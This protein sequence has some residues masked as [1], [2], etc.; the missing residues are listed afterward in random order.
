MTDRRP[1]GDGRAATGVRRRS[2]KR[3]TPRGCVELRA[4]LYIPHTAHSG[5]NSGTHGRVGS[6]HFALLRA[7]SELKDQAAGSKPHRHGPWCRALG[8]LCEV[9]FKVHCRRR[10]TSRSGACT[11]RP[12]PPTKPPWSFI[13]YTKSPGVRAPLELDLE[14]PKLRP[15]NRA[16]TGRGPVDLRGF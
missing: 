6:F 11:P 4:S 9:N 2:R 8:A 5:S 3:H 7:R 14:S 15:R 12:T 13:Q 1:R 10:P 16:Q